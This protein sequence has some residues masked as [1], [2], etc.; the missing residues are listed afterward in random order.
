V[1]DGLHQLHMNGNRKMTHQ[2]PIAKHER[3]ISQVMR[4][5]W[6][7]CTHIDNLA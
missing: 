4:Q 7:D 5:Y 6:H 2:G 1:E 3:I